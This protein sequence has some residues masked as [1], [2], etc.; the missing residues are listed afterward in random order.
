MMNEQTIA[1]NSNLPGKFNKGRVIWSSRYRE[2]RTN[3]Q[4]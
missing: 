4:K 2:M 1:D 3:E